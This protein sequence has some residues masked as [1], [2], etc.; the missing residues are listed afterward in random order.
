MVS[1]GV[2]VDTMNAAITSAV[3][4]SGSVVSS[5]LASDRQRLEKVEG[6][7]REMQLK[8]ER[9]RIEEEVAARYKDEL[10]DLKAKVAGVDK[11][12]GDLKEEHTAAMKAKDEEALTARKLLVDELDAMRLAKVVV[13]FVPCVCVY[14]DAFCQEADAAKA[15]DDALK[16]ADLARLELKALEVV[17]ARLESEN[18]AVKD[19]ELRVRK[20]LVSA[21]S[22]ARD[23]LQSLGERGLEVKALEV[24]IARLEAEKSAEI[25]ARRALEAGM[26]HKVR[27]QSPRFEFLAGLGVCVQC[28]CG[29]W[30]PLSQ[31]EEHAMATHAC[32]T[33]RPLICTSGCGFFF[34]NGSRVDLEKHLRSYQCR[35]RLDIIEKL[36][37]GVV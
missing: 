23:F 22:R 6:Q 12:I 18:S 13:C 16:A 27:R 34:V 21:R 10:N 32:G 29:V 14:T 20:A 9:R 28:K 31:M 5:A 7:L 26:S 15:N 25:D 2:M 3:S 30:V 36:G 33:R 35:K 37:S 4:S 8:E 17:I 11:T 24:V 19:A 1:L